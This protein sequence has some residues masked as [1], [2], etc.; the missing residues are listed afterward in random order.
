MRSTYPNFKNNQVLPLAKILVGDVAYCLQNSPGDKILNSQSLIRLFAHN[1]KDSLNLLI[2][3]LTDYQD[4][5]SYVS[6]L[7]TQRIN[8]IN[9]ELKRYL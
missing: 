9:T 4:D 2:Q 7:H 5:L 1:H 6:E 3:C 8:W